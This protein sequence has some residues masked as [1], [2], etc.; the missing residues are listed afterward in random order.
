MAQSN[1][2]GVPI[3]TEGQKLVGIITKRDLRFLERGD[4]PIAE[5]M[6]P[7]WAGHGDWHGNA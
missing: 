5:I 6:T 2:S 3:T 7:N 1:I 4:T